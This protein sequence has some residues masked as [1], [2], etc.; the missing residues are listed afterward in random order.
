MKPDKIQE[1]LLNDL[2]QYMQVIDKLPLHSQ[3]KI[4]I[5][6]CHVYRK[7]KWNQG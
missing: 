6:S 7:L 1:I 3:N 2:N 5:A 4:M